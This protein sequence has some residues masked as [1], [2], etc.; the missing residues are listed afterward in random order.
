[1]ELTQGNLAIMKKIAILICEKYDQF[2]ASSDNNIL[3]SE[4]K[5]IKL[6]YDLVIWDRPHI[7][8]EQYSF[9][10]IRATWDYSYGKRN[11]LLETL[12]SIANK[13]IPIFNSPHLV[14]WNSTKRY[15]LDLQ[16]KG[17]NIIKTLIVTPDNFVGL[18]T[19]I[20]QNS[21]AEYILK[22]LISGG[23]RNTYRVARKDISS[24][25]KFHFQ[26]NEDVIIQPFMSTIANGEWSLI[27]FQNNYSHA[28][29]SKPADGDFRVQ[30]KHGG[31][32]RA[33]QP[34]EAMLQESKKILSLLKQD[35]PL[36]ARIDFICEDDRLYLME[37]ELIEPI[38]FFSWS[39]SAATRFAHRI[40]GISK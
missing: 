7:N 21:S 33:A 3:F 24:T 20:E 26:K 16:Q 13:G 34:T 6:E 11:K 22:P 12:D 40:S 17:V 32:V 35:I 39:P 18:N 38:L 9:V 23:A 25:L 30:I 1:M 31:K 5:K 36:Y 27:Y 2:P 10:L 4:L 8:W 14:R 15:L 19:F 28:V 37:L 29:L